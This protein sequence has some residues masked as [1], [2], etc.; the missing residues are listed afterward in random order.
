MSWIDDADKEENKTP[1]EWEEIQELE[2]DLREEN[3]QLVVTERAEQRLAPRGESVIAEQLGVPKLCDQCYLIDKCPKYEKGATCFFRNTVK[4]EGPQSMMELMKLM[5]E[6]QGERVL[7]GRFIEQ[8]EGGYIDSNLSKEMKMMMDLMKDFKDLVS[9][10]EDEISIKIK[11]NP[12]KAA[13]EAQQSAGGI[14]GQIFGNGG[15]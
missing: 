13:G 10:P 2:H 14:L 3:K 12:A 9:K 6:V 11:G 5:L 7:F 8:S 4:I 15:K 1:A